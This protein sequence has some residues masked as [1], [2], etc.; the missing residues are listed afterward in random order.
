V[1]IFALEGN[2]TF[3]FTSFKRSHLP[4]IK[5]I[6]WNSKSENK[7]VKLNLRLTG[8]ILLFFRYQWMNPKLE[9]LKCFYRFR[10]GRCYN[11]N[12]RRFSTIFDN[13]RRKKL[14]FFSKTNVMIKILHNLALLWVKTPIFCW[15]FRW[16][17]LNNHNIGP[18]LSWV[19]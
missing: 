14:A 7:Y 10:G 18:R 4:G 17:Y 1:D 3:N 19:V 8:R 12:F 5:W 16:K 11:H 6:E 13:F 9:R 2:N 15:I